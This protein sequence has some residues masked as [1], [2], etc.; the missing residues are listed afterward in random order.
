MAKLEH[1]D[2]MDDQDLL[3]LLV[4]MDQAAEMESL[5]NRDLVVCQDKVDPVD[6]MDALDPLDPQDLPALLEPLELLAT[7]KDTLAHQVLAAATRD[8]THT[9]LITETMLRSMRTTLRTAS[10]SSASA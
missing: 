9:V 10:S 5:D 6:P 4:S 8:L 7:H 3:D 1:V 2:P